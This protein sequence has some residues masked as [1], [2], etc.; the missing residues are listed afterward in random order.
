[1]TVSEYI[2]PAAVPAPLRLA[3]LA[4]L[5]GRPPK[6]LWE[7]VRAL[8]PQAL[9]LCGDTLHRPFGRERERGLACLRAAAGIAPVFCSLG[10]HETA[11]PPAGRAALCRDIR[12]TGAV[13]L[14][15]EAVRFGGLLIGGLPS[16]YAADAAGNACFIE[17]DAAFLAR[18]AAASG[19]KLLLFH[20]PELYAPYIRPLPIRL[21][22]AGH[23]HG[24]QWQIGGRGIYAPGQG[25]LPAL[26]GGLYEGRLLVSRGLGNPCHLPRFSNPPEVCCLTLLPPGRTADQPLPPVGAAA[27]AAAQNSRR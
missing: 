23:A 12:E 7:R 15:N 14:D 16:P 4:D 2:V 11:C 22:V 27:R 13:L 18:F 1:M 10:N 21:T 3:V 20:H 6:G 25:L 19:E 9:L 26:T 17:P 5:H 24:G 8:R